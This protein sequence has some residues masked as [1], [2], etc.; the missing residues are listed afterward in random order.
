MRLLTVWRRRYRQVY[1]TMRART[2]F[3]AFVDSGAKVVLLGEDQV[4][5]M[6][7]IRATPA[8]AVAS[9]K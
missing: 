3:A 7:S 1:G 2:W 8:M 9:A 6:V 5:R 4:G